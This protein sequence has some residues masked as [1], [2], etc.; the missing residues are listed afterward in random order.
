[1]KA[2]NAPSKSKWDIVCWG[3]SQEEIDVCV[4]SN[5]KKVKL[6]KGMEQNLLDKQRYHYNIYYIIV[7]WGNNMIYIENLLLESGKSLKTL[8][9]GNEVPM[10][11]P[12]TQEYLGIEKF[13]VLSWLAFRF[14]VPSRIGD[15]GIEMGFGNALLFSMNEHSPFSYTLY[16]F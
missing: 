10:L 7:S 9:R 4:A 2:Q 12:Y 11:K 13:N 14:I 3:I 1:M 5:S 6:A 15:I 8:F 16:E